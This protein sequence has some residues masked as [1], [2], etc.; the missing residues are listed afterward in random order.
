MWFSADETYLNIKSR[1]SDA[2]IF[3][4]FSTTEAFFIDDI[5]SGVTKIA[6]S[7]KTAVYL[8][9]SIMS[10]VFCPKHHCLVSSIHLLFHIWK[11]VTQV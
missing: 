3:G 9:Q 11:Y 5:L 4:F 7:A 1:K 6:F 10:D 2:F 8:L